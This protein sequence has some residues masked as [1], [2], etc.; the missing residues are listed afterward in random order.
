[1]AKTRAQR[2]AELFEGQN[3]DILRKVEAPEGETLTPS[4]G[5]PIR[6][7]YLVRNTVTGDELLVSKTTLK[8]MAEDFYAVTLPGNM[9]PHIK[10]RAADGAA[11][12][13]T[14]PTDEQPTGTVYGDD[15]LN[16]EQ[17]PSGDQYNEF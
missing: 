5:R 13:G 17:S 12:R 1:M 9:K 14:T 4:I 6:T 7:G 8:V 2:N 11:D 16:N 10:N 3:F 15:Q